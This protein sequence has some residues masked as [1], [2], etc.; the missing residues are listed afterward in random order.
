MIDENG[1]NAPHL[2]HWETSQSIRQLEMFLGRVCSS[3]WHLMDRTRVEDEKKGM[4]HD[5]WRIKANDFWLSDSAYIFL[6]GLPPPKVGF[7]YFTQYNLSWWW[8]W[9]F[10]EYAWYLEQ[11]SIWIHPRFLKIVQDTWVHPCKTKA[12][13]VLERTSKVALTTLPPMR[14]TEEH[15]EWGRIKPVQRI[16][17]D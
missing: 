17:Q 12:L 16:S 13:R 11:N 1:Y 6:A 10:Q 9:M 14:I 7:L 15:N 3:G 8:S 4:Y 2:E 5:L